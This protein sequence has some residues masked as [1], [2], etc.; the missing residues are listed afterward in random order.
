[1]QE[2]EIRRRAAAEGVQ[3][4]TRA[5]RLFSAEPAW[6]II[7][8]LLFVLVNLVLGLIPLLG[9]LVLMLI[10]PALV[11]G[12]LYAAREQDEGRVITAGHLFQ[13]LRDA[14]R[15]GPML[16]LGLVQLL[17]SFL[18][19]L[20][21]MVMMSGVV[22]VGGMGEG[23]P[24]L[25]MHFTTG[26]LTGL[27]LLMA[28]MLMM[29]LLFLYAIPLVM[30]TATSPL[31]AMRLSLQAG[32]INVWPLSVLGLVFVPLW[33]LGMLSFGL[34]YLVVIPLTFIS[35]YTSYTRIFKPRFHIEELA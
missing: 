25:D 1:M 16:M 14:S 29:T 8:I 31:A 2:L 10:T 35:I 4:F 32:L 5:W 30:F 21:G 6:W 13:G 26:V 17:L 34:G 20:L 23:M 22:G 18:A 9:G 24:P 19:L 33:L 7:N 28:L 27:L 15:R 3:W 12:L 11:G